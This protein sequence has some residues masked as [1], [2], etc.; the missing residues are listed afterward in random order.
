ML[1]IVPAAGAAT[2][3]Q[4]LAFSKEMLPVGSVVDEHGIERPKAVSEFLVERMIHAG[5]DRICFVLSPEKTDIIPYYARHWAA[6]RFCYVVQERPFGLC[7]ALF[8]ALH[9]LREDEDVLIGLP[10][11]VWFPLDGFGRLPPD[12]LSFL[13]FQVEDAR[14]FD[15]V[16]TGPDGRVRE[17]RVKSEQP[18]T[19]WVWG[20]FRMPAS[21]LRTLHA[22]W[23]EPERGDEYVGTLVNAYLARGGH[24][25]GITAG[26]RYY[27]VGTV[28]G[29]RAAIDVL[30]GTGPIRTVAA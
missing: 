13:L 26:E 25:V 10:D 23:S 2:R 28:D 29:Y 22:L 1:G 3:L 5:A 14:R 21:T 8:R 19:N 4:P 27:D 16:L 11:T 6:R 9:V 18:G 17:I 12:G 20:A 24:A 30:R 15:A 7:D